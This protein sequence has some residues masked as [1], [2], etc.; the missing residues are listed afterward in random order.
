MPFTA[1][2]TPR[3]NR[4]L[5]RALSWVNNVAV[6]PYVARVRAVRLPQEDTAALA[7]HLC[8]PAVICRNHPE[9]FTDWMLDKWLTSRYASLAACWAAPEIVNG[10]GALATRFWLA[11]NLVAAVRGDGL[12]AA[13]EYSAGSLAAGHGAL[14]HPEGEVNWDNEAL[15]RLKTGCVQI[16]RR[17]ATRAGKSA[18]IVPVAWFIRFGEDATSGLTNSISISLLH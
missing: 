17:G 2:H 14:I 15:G 4:A 5:I 6:L 1:F 13:L 3:Q 9:F 12:D 16:V 8:A 18:L 10:M 7:A 11:N